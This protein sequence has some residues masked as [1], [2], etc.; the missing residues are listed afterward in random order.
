M[1]SCRAA[2]P[3]PEPRGLAAARP[4]AASELDFPAWGVRVTRVPLATSVAE[5]PDRVIVETVERGDLARGVFALTIARDGAR[6]RAGSEALARAAAEDW[7]RQDVEVGE[8]QEIELLGAPGHA[9]RAAAPDAAVL[10]V[11]AVRGDVVYHLVVMHADESA[12]VDY[13]SSVLKTIVL[14]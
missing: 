12:L 7:R 9:F 4:V 1:V 2:G 10:D 6:A 11:T 3:A 5:T 8:P 14:R 13:A